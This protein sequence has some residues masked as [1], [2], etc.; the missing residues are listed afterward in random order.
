M[1][2]SGTCALFA[3][4]IFTLSVF[5]SACKETGTVQV[6]SITFNGNQAIDANSLKAVIATQENSRLPFSR[7]H[8]FDRPEFE[9]DLQR[10]EAYYADHGYPHA[11]VTGVDVKLNNAKDHVDITINITEGAPTIVESIAFEG[12][13]AI[14]A[15]HLAKLKAQ[16]PVVAGEPRNQTLILAA[17]DLAVNE[18]R[19]HGFPYGTV[20]IEERPGSGPDRVQLALVADTGPSAVVGAISIEGNASVDE[21]VIRR[22][23][24][25]HEGS[26][27][28]LSDITESQ[29][30]LYGLELFQFANITPRLPE[31]RAPQVPVVV[32]V[33]E[34]K[35]RRLQLAVGYGSEEK[36]RGKVNWRH[37]NFTGGAR[38]VE[39]EAKWSSLEHGFRGTFTEPYLVTS[40]LRLQLQGSSWWSSE[41][42]YTY[43]SSGG[44]VILT[45]ELGH[46]AA[47]VMAGT[48][49][50]VRVS[51]INEHE[52]YAITPSALTDLSLRDQF[53][54]LGLDPTTGKGNGTLSA[55]EIDFDRD[56][57]ERRLDPRHGY[58]ISTHLETADSWLGG[59]FRYN[60]LFGEARYYLPIGKSVVWANRVKAGSL[61]G[62]DG[63]KIPFFK[64]YF[65]GGSTS[66]RGWGRYQVSPLS[67]EGLPIGGRTMSEVSTEG[68]FPITGKWSGVL[69]VDGGNVWAKAGDIKP[70]GLRWAA[71]PGLR[72]DTPIGPL[73]VDLGIQ[74]NPIQ[75]LVINGSPERRRWRV[76]FSIGQAF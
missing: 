49:N 17:H 6:S 31:N 30:R 43:R 25:I 70:S 69:F 15:D 57:S 7:S 13:D 1:R 16:T 48:H 26:E 24:T 10:V 2:H 40:G 5:V 38:T 72:Y 64:R 34:G 21:S 39:T 75:G 9:R 58:L 23:L 8:Y 61:L 51:L 60:E 42:V 22:E 12:L 20:K 65:V 62:G 55:I 44:R 59:S 46:G 33:A 18:L 29:R 35:H 37:V 76:H 74:L 47:G 45:K 32:T 27:Y 66:V 50:E 67:D 52:T 41:P 63:S 14:P 3:L 53:I 19:D 56:T 68:R 28:R 36:A 11:K 54:A 71:G 73:R 4:T